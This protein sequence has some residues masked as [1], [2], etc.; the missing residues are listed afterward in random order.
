MPGIAAYDD[1]LLP[2]I[3]YVTF[4]TCADER[5]VYFCDFVRNI[6]QFQQKKSSAGV[7]FVIVVVDVLDGVDG[8]YGVYGVMVVHVQVTPP[9]NLFRLII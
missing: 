7:L 2:M 9:L 8:V 6:G 1:V 4:L 5:V 3:F